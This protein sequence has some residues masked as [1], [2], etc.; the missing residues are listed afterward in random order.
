MLATRSKVQA[1][2]I[3]TIQASVFA[4]RIQLVPRYS[5][6]N[7]YVNVIMKVE[8]RLNERGVGVAQ[9]K[10]NAQLGKQSRDLDLRTGNVMISFNTKKCRSN[11]L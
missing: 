3:T 5:T 10:I 1:D 11:V 4:Q 6:V 2:H 9:D 8:I 7:R